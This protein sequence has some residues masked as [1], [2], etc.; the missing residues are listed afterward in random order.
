MRK[1]PLVPVLGAIVLF[2]SGCSQTVANE[3]HVRTRI[4][5]SGTASA[6]I[7][8]Y[9]EGSDGNAVTGAV[10]Q[11]LDSINSVM[12][13]PF[14]SQSCA[15]AGSRSVPADGRFKIRVQS[16]LLK[17]DYSRTIPHTLLDS[18]PQLSDFR[19]ASGNS[20]LEGKALH[21]N[22]PWHLGWQSLGQGVVYS[23]TF[24]TATKV[25]YSV[26]TEACSITVPAGTLGAGSTWYVEIQ[27]QRIIGDPDYKDFDYCSSSCSGFANVNFNV[28]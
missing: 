8:V 11:V 16:V 13:L 12:S 14:D 26:S 28:Q 3:V 9:V 2:L 1:Y 15:Y 21:V 25:F 27:A 7:S 5:S 18:K 23:I 20:V 19:D 4:E 24:R 22:E 17:S 6:T 10:V